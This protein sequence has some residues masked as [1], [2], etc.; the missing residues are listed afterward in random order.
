[1][2][3]CILVK[4][5]EIDKTL[6][7]KPIQGKRVL[8]P[9]SSLASNEGLPFNIL[10]DHEITNN[11]AEVHKQEGDL[12]CCLEGEVEFT[13]GGELVNSEFRKNPDG[14]DNTNELKGSGI[15][16]GTK[17]IL[18]QGDWLWIPP[19]QPHLHNTSKTAR[20]IIIKIPKI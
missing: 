18:K 4:K 19:G 10:E 6:A 8:E 13:Y 1:M 16:D 9:I 7:N 3:N 2:E 20:L 5:E 12:W 17:S 14:S 11:E 15:K